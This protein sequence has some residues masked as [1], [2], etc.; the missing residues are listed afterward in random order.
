M[1]EIIM[2]YDIPLK[3]LLI[4]PDHDS[5]DILLPELQSTDSVISTKRVES[6]EDAKKVLIECDINTIFID[7]IAIELDSASDFIFTIR[8]ELPEIVFVLYVDVTLAEQ[9]RAEFYRG[10]RKRF[11]H[12]FWLDKRTPVTMFGKEVRS[13]VKACQSDLSWAMSTEKIAQL[14]KEAQILQT[15]APK[16]EFAEEFNTLLKSLQHLLNEISKRALNT[17]FAVEP[18]TVFLSHRFADIEYVSGITELL[19]KNG[20][21]VITGSDANTYVSKAI[22]ERIQSCEYFLCLLTKK[23]EKM[24][25]TFTTS[26][27][28]LE[29]KGVALT[30]QKPLVL[31]VEEGVSDIGGLQGDWQRIH[32]TPKGFLKAALKAV[33]QL[34]SYRGESKHILTTGK[35]KIRER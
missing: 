13:V 18:N 35:E 31:M 14:Q 17:E 23:D 24:D 33:E 9:Q 8:E 34:C 3:I 28:I 26:P 2:L 19:E 12:Y 15:R 27:W 20:F 25:G 29:E 4:D 21:T 10:K 6:L 7:P 30:L 5:A 22:I 11:L 1:E 32:F 16:Q